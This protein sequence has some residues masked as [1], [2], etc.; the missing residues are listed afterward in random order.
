VAQIDAR[1]AE[2]TERRR[3]LTSPTESA[4]FDPSSRTSL[5]GQARAS[6]TTAPVDGPEAWKRGDPSKTYP[7]ESP[8]SRQ[9]NNDPYAY[10]PPRAQPQHTTPR[11][12]YDS[13]APIDNDLRA[14][15]QRETELARRRMEVSKSP[16]SGFAPLDP[17]HS[18]RAGRV[19]SDS[20][21]G[22]E[23][24]GDV[25][26]QTDPGSVIPRARRRGPAT[27]ETKGAQQS[28][29]GPV[30]PDVLAARGRVDATRKSEVQDVQAGSEQDIREKAKELERRK[31]DL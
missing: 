6:A 26:A 16:L 21:K 17:G 1:D 7:Y 8:A 27:A 15:S 3:L 9:S 11:D 24:R 18:E 25:D 31:D 5:G 28:T 20:V 2:E 29:T 22:D 12:T 13:N 19:T 10:T 14:K 23:R 4:E 30:D